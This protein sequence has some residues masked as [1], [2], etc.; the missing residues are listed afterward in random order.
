MLIPVLAIEV[1]V[2]IFF[3]PKK[4]NLL[5]N[6]KK[7]TNSFQDR[8]NFLL[9]IFY[10][11][12]ISSVLYLTFNSYLHYKLRKFTFMCEVFLNGRGEA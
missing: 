4:Y 2:Q 10:L 8:S 6:K 5:L 9:N 3:Y 11:S 7:N 1:I 12:N